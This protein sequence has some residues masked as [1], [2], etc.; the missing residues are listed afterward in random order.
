MGPFT[1]IRATPPFVRE[2]VWVPFA[3][4]TPHLQSV[5]RNLYK[6]IEGDRVWFEELNLE[7]GLAFRYGWATAQD[8]GF[9]RR[10]Q[11]E[12]LTDEPRSLRLVDGLRHVLPPG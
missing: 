3:E 1:A 4:H 7:L 9:V 5:R 8:Y 12:N 11:L 6:S 10:C 2:G